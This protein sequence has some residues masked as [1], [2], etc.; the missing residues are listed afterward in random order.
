VFALIHFLP[1]NS[2]CE[3]KVFIYVT[4]PVACVS[5]FTQQPVSGLSGVTLCDSQQ[6]ISELLQQNSSASRKSRNFMCGS[7]VNRNE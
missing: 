5:C 3:Q 1:L 2:L 7:C 6:T 4:S